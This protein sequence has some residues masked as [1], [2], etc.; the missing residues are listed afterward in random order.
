[1]EFLSELSVFRILRLVHVGI[2]EASVAPGWPPFP[3]FRYPSHSNKFQHNFLHFFTL[4]VL[5]L[6]SLHGAV[7]QYIDPP[8]NPNSTIETFSFERLWSW[9]NQDFDVINNKNQTKVITIE[10]KVKDQFQSRFA[11]YL[12]LLPSQEHLRV[13]VNGRSIWCG[14]KQTYKIMNNGTSVYQFLIDP[15]GMGVDR[16]HIKKSGNLTHSYTW[17]R[18][19]TGLAGV[20]QRDDKRKVAYFKAKAWGSE[21]YAAVEHSHTPGSTTYTIITNGEVPLEVLAALYASAAV[22]ADYC[23]W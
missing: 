1:M 21:D 12:T 14:F 23:S 7:S 13:K 10:T 4:A 8:T 15:R 19:A 20:V 22:R 5:L 16:W 3:N 6:P 2:H 18:H 11:L 17:R 9:S